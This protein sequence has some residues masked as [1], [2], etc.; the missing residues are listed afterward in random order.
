MRYK[1]K[2]IGFQTQNI[3]GPKVRAKRPKN[4]SPK[5]TSCLH[6]LKVVTLF[7]LARARS[8]PTVKIKNNI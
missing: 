1:T 7:D 8:K 2:P 6:I 5:L 4:P 3:H